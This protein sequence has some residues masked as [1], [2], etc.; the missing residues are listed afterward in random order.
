[1][2][3]LLFPVFRSRNIFRIDISG[4]GQIRLF[5]TKRTTP[6]Y[7]VQHCS[8]LDLDTGVI[9]RLLGDSTLWPHIMALRL[10]SETRKIFTVFVF[11]DSVEKKIYRSLMV[12]LRC[13]KNH[14]A[15]QLSL[16]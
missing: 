13:V 15:Q 4:N 9:V 3:A 11:P 2:F 1:V 8:E 6:P 10:Q 5:Q 16:P 14:E 7:Q 12:A